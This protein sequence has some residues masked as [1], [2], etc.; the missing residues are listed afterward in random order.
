MMRVIY[1]WRGVPHQGSIQNP[2]F[3]YVHVPDETHSNQYRHWETDNLY[4][5]EVHTDVVTIETIATT[6]L[7]GSVITSSE[8]HFH[9]CN[10]CGARSDKDFSS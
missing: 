1:G 3:R 4:V 5:G 2:K 9:R 7:N 8:S 10:I 6:S